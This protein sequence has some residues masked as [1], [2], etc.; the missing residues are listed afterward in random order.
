VRKRH[1]DRSSL[2]RT[3]VIPENGPRSPRAVS[4]PLRLAR[5]TSEG[6]L[7]PVWLSAPPGSTVDGMPTPQHPINSRFSADNPSQMSWRVI[8]LTGKL[9]IVTGG[10]SGLGA[11]VTLGLTE[12]GTTVVVP[13]RRP[14][15]A[16]KEIGS[17]EHVKIDELDLAELGSVN[18]HWHRHETQLLEAQTSANSLA[19]STSALDR[20]SLVAPPDLPPAL[21]VRNC[22][23]GSSCTRST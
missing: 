17:I 21:R 5:V 15:Q 8:D 12:A 13:A 22:S 4:C 1:A 23:D 18:C 16:R 3:G 11:A 10:Y 2:P 7:S 6:E 20:N 19:R 14:A 9:A